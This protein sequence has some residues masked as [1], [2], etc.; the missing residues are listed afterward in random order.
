LCASVI[1]MVVAFWMF[2]RVPAIITLAR[3]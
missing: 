1:G 3:R 2:D